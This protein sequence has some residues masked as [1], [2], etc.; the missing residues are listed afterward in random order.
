MDPVLSQ[1]IWWEA[2]LHEQHL[3]RA[4]F[5][6]QEKIQILPSLMLK[7]SLAE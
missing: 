5:D 6:R 7:H 3:Q 1:S 2:A 4:D